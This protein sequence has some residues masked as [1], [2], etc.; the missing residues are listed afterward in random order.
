MALKAPFIAPCCHDSRTGGLWAGGSLIAPPRQIEPFG[1]LW[2]LA[3]DSL[4]HYAECDALR[5]AARAVGGEVAAHFGI[6]DDG[7]PNWRDAAQVFKRLSHDLS[8]EDV[9]QAALMGAGLCG[10]RERAARIGSSTAEVLPRR[11]HTR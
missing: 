2:C 8:A 4:Q 10:L 5:V 11:R 6:L 1:D 7:P 9:A 3:P